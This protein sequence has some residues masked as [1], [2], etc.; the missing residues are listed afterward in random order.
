MN[1]R[2][3][4]QDYLGRWAFGLSW[5]YLATGQKNPNNPINPVQLKN[6]KTES[7][8]ASASSFRIEDGSVAI[9][10]AI[11]SGVAEVIK[12]QMN[13]GLFMW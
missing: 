12:Y 8:G 13:D 3:D 1:I 7:S 6:L 2:Q 5:G 10:K 4:L 11:S 9:Q